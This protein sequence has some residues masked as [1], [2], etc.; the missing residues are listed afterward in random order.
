MEHTSEKHAVNVVV[1]GARNPAV[2][3]LG[4]REGALKEMQL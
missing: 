3:S 2:P 4:M 1:L